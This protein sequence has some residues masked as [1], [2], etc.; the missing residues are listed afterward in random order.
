MRDFKII[1]HETEVVTTY[2]TFKQSAVGAEIAQRKKAEAA[3]YAKAIQE[4]EKRAVRK[5]CP[6][7]SDRHDVKC[8]EKCAMHHDGRCGLATGERSTDGGDCPFANYPIKCSS[9]C[10]LYSDGCTFVK[11]GNEK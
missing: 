5:S 10:A 9:A 6:F 1:E 8:Q 7:R 4:A 2:G 11:K 3:A